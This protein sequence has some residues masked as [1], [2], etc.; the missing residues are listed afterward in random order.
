MWSL[1]DLCAEVLELELRKPHDLRR[2][3]WEKRPLSVDQLS[4]AATD[5]YAGLRLWQVRKDLMANIA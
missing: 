1:A 4:Y 3:N 2:G 5:A